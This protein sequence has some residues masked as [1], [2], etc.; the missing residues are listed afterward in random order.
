MTIRQPLIGWYRKTLRA[1]LVAGLALTSCPSNSQT[2]PAVKPL[3]GI[4]ETKGGF[5]FTGDEKKVRKL[6]QSVSGIACSVDPADSAQRVC[7]LVFDEGTEA[8]HATIRN[9]T[10][11][12]DSEVVDLRP[13]GGEL[14]AEAA[15]IA[16]G[17]FY[18]VGS[19]SATRSRCES[20]P[21]SRFVV[22]FEI[23]PGTGRAMRVAPG[24][25][26]SQLKGYQATNRLWDIMATLEPLRNHVGEGKCLGT[27]PP[28][29]ALSLKGQRGVNIEGLAARAGRLYFGFRGP[30]QNGIVPVLSVEANALFSGADAKPAIHR[31]TVGNGRGIRDMH[32]VKDGILV[33]AGPDDDS[34]HDN[35]DWTVSWWSGTP[36]PSE[37]IAVTKTLARLDLSGVGLRKK[38][39]KE[40]KPEAIAV[41]GETDQ[42]YEL[43][44]LSDGM[45][46]GG[47]LSFQIKRQP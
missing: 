33:L 17:Y 47:A 44:V 30:A 45:C 42:A 6:R 1:A 46:D 41:V 20:N 23:N 19:H 43:V 14:D 39:D 34:A 8:R 38:C 2:A 32:A 25:A 12:A 36:G 16:D 18:V 27:S 3:D 7:L 31:L 28:P 4:W 29:K 37:T 24:S 26:A 5:G 40:I 35:L 22:R 10:L 21:N 11:H 15:A 9:R 13:Q